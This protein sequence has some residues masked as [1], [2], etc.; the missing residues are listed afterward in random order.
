MRILRGVKHGGG[1]FNLF[2]VKELKIA[3]DID[4]RS[5]ANAPAATPRDLTTCAA[6]AKRKQQ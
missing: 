1:F 2:I 4:A 3:A 6:A 5:R